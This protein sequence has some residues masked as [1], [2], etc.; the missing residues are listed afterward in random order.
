MTVLTFSFRWNGILQS[1]KL[2]IEGLDIDMSTEDW[3]WNRPENVTAQFK[4]KHEGVETKTATLETSY[5]LIENTVVLGMI[6][7]DKQIATIIFTIDLAD[8]DLV[9]RI[10]KFTS[11]G[12]FN[13]M[14]YDDLEI[15]R[16]HVRVTFDVDV[17][18]EVLFEECC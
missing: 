17:Y 18:P 16:T 8:N 3:K 11:V 12:E 5:A 14:F 4:Y 7:N 6:H 10:G 13:E 9:I 1:K 2:V 15:E